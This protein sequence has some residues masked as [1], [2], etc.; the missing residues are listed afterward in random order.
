MRNIS[1]YLFVVLD[2]TPTSWSRRQYNKNETNYYNVKDSIV[3]IE[4]SDKKR[5]KSQPRISSSST[6][7]SR[8]KKNPLLDKVKHTRL[9]CFRSNSNVSVINE[10]AFISSN[11]TANTNFTI[12]DVDDVDSA[13]HEVN[14]N[15]SSTRTSCF[16]AKIR[17][18]SEK[19]LNSSTNKLV[20]KIYKSSPGP[21]ND[22]Y[23]VRA[24]K[25]KVIKKRSFSYGA[26]PDLETFQNGS[27]SCHQNGLSTNEDDDYLPLVDNEDSDSGILLNDSFSSGFDS[28]FDSSQS[29]VPESSPSL[30]SRIER[31]GRKIPQ[32]AQSLDRKEILK[33]SLTN[34]DVFGEDMIAS[35]NKKVMVV[36]MSKRHSS[37]D[38]GIV[39]AKSK[40][41]SHGYIVARIIP[42]GVAAR[43]VLFYDK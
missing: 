22:T 21:L 27:L 28:S 26:L 25:K 32:R 20:T 29:Y 13:A 30:R 42:H 1:D 35:Q 19:Y 14:K 3:I 39:I 9:S 23:S 6:S 31:S 33:V 18:M 40:Q 8:E 38:L 2:T 7:C 10:I 4:K 43:Y 37:D 24:S 36:K 41:I 5:H 12:I 17:A 16:A 11:S 15:D 34:H